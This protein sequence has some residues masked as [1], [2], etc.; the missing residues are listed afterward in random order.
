MAGSID[1]MGLA[2][3]VYRYGCLRQEEIL[4]SATYTLSV[5]H[6]VTNQPPKNIFWAENTLDLT[7]IMAAY[8]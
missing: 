7:V 5:L 4:Q 6:T 2:C 8:L 3:L 1:T